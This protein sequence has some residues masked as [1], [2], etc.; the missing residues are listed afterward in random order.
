MPSAIPPHESETALPAG[1]VVRSPFALSGYP[2]HRAGESL[3]PQRVSQKDGEGIML[4]DIGYLFLPDGSHPALPGQ[5]GPSGSR[6]DY[7][8]ALPDCPDSH[9]ERPQTDPHSK[10]RSG[11]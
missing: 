7:A 5:P 9:K 4:R 2:D 1:S 8:V 10:D 3:S 11:S 6:R